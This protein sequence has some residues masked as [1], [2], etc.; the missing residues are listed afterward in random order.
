MMGHLT[1]FTQILLSS[2]IVVKNWGEKWIKKGVIAEPLLDCILSG[3][4]RKGMAN[5]VRGSKHTDTI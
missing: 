2:L 4:H 5:E 3:G 1:F